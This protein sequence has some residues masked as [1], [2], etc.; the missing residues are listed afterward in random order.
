M[1]FQKL[2]DITRLTQEIRQSSIS[3]ALDFINAA[4]TNCD[5]QF[6]SVLSTTDTATL[7]M[8]VNNHIPVPLPNTTIQSVA[9]VND[10]LTASGRPQVSVYEPEG[11]AA[12]IV[13][14]NFC[15]KTTWWMTAVPV[16]METLTA[17]TVSTS[18]FNTLHPF[19]IDL[20]HGNCYDEDTFTT[21]D[22]S[23][24]PTVYVDDVLRTTGYS[25]NYRT[26]AITFDVPVVGTVKASYKY[27]INS[28]FILKPRDGQ[29]LSI[30]DAQVQFSS[31]N[32]ISSPV[33]FEAWIDTVSY[34]KVAIPS[35]R[36]K[37]KNERDLIYAC[38]GG[39]EIIKGWGNYIF[40]TVVLIFNYARPKPI[41]SS[42]KVEI[43]IYIQ[44]HVELIG[45]LANAT[46]YVTSEKE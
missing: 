6:K 28:Y 9:I 33:I 39:Q 32:V 10:K 29:V 23:L 34:G 17:S 46:F 35:T 27:A 2:V 20:T 40:D 14:Y 26:G 8:I 3:V 25:I 4:G 42:S 18:I 24:I 16:V 11:S 38:N 15:D 30:K 12:T 43:R 5:V 7:N 44:N 36:I 1:I 31:N 22:P 13:S 37:Y 41:K 21:A 45:S 19:I